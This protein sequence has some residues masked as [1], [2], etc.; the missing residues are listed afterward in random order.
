MRHRGFERT[1]RASQNP[2]PVRGLS[3]GGKSD[4]KKEVE[5]LKR[6]QSKYD[7]HAPADDDGL[8]LDPFKYGRE[9]GWC[10]R[11]GSN[12]DYRL[13]HDGRWICMGCECNV[14]PKPPPL[15]NDKQ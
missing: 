2:G 9:Q 5:A 13:R 4:L 10:N 6:E 14:E 7:P 1:R 12:Q 3:L 8:G 15:R 11:C